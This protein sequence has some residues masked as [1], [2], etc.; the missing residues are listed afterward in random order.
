MG[1]RLSW[2]KRW[3]S[4]FSRR[5]RRPSGGARCCSYAPEISWKSPGAVQDFWFAGQCCGN[6]LYPGIFLLLLLLLLLPK[7]LGQRFQWAQII[8]QKGSDNTQIIWVIL[9]GSYIWHNTD[10]Y[11]K[12][13]IWGLYMTTYFQRFLWNCDV[14]E[15]RKKIL[16]NF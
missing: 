11:N 3:L 15:R 14:F 5:A 2:V 6:F 7:P 4:A 9:A 16:A 1:V 12:L 8:W 10:R 13:L